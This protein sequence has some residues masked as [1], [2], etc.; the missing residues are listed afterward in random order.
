MSKLT[1]IIEKDK[2]NCV[3]KAA[4]LFLDSSSR[5]AKA[6]PAAVDFDF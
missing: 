3:T 4:V 6:R 2:R 5:S 1:A